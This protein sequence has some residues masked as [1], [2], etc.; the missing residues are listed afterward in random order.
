MKTPNSKLVC[1]A[2]SIKSQMTHPSHSNE[3]VRLKRIKG[4][5]EG[6]ERMILEGRYCPEILIQIRAATAALK[7][8]ER[9]ILGSHLRACV[10][11]AMNSRNENE[12]KSKIDE[13]MEL[14]ASDHRK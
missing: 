9:S 13:L 7:T 14:F 4:Q 2:P 11:D 3:I 1:H 5:V 12:I 10:Q 6:V 8:V